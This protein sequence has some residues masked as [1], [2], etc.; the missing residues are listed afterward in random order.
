MW[1]SDF[2]HWGL[3]LILYFDFASWL[4]TLDARYPVR[5][6]YATMAMHDDTSAWT[7][8]SSLLDQLDAVDTEGLPA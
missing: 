2:L 6:A 1:I 8:S 7:S 3:H 4:F 5:V